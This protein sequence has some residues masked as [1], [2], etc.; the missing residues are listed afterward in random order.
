MA[1]PFLKEGRAQYCHAAPVGKLILKG[2]GFS[3]AGRCASPEYYRCQLVAKDEPHQQTCPHLEEVHVQYCGVSTPT[4]LIPFSESQVS[5]C[6]TGGYRFC[7]SYLT[8]ARPHGAMAPSKDL[9]YSPNHF[10]LAAEESGLCHIGVDAF[11]AEFVGK[12]DGITFVTTHGTLRPVIALTIHGVEWPMTFPNLLLIQKVNS[13]LRGDSAR[14]TADPYGSGWLFSGWEL[15]GQTKA[16]LIA[17]S[18]AAAWQT[19]EEERLAREIH[20]SLR[21][22]C[23]GGRPV[24][25]IAEL[26]SRA[27]LVCQLQHFFSN[28][29]WAPKDRS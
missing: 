15:P 27:Q 20:E 13:H 11:L 26:L 17:G 9:L 7:E 3:G 21:L 5:N 19:E 24:L 12:V 22:H 4:K 10:W 1:C 25:G 16:G 2:P 6:T 28:R 29:N 8:L 23:D 14:L 18:P